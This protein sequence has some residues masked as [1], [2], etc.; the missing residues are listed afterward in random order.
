M[1]IEEREKKDIFNVPEGYFEQLHDRVMQQLPK[2]ERQAI[3]SRNIFLRR[4]VRM[5]YAAAAAITLILCLTTFYH[6]NRNIYNDEFNDEIIEDLLTENP[7]DDYTFF[8]YLA[9]VE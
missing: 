3:R 6:Y 4:V 8:C 5:S 9:D 1:R 7:I 2:E